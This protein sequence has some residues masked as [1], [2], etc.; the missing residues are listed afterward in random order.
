MATRSVLII[1]RW[2]LYSRYYSNTIIAERTDIMSDNVVSVSG[3]LLHSVPPY[4]S[5]GV[6]ESIFNMERLKKLMQNMRFF[7]FFGQQYPWIYYLNVYVPPF[8]SF[9]LRKMKKKVCWF[10]V[11]KSRMEL[12]EWNKVISLSKT[13]WWAMCLSDLFRDS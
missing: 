7:K 4:C 2:Q 6:K 11:W 3:S 8:Y 1:Q 5:S 9:F 12:Q 13:D 10:Q